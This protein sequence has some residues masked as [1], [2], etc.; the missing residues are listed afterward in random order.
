MYTYD[1]CCGSC[2]YLNTNDYSSSKDRCRCTY[3]EMYCNLKDSKCSYYRY[4]PNKD[5]YDLNHRWHIVSVIRAILPEA[6]NLPGF[7]Q[8]WN[9]RVSVLEKDQRYSAALTLYDIIGPFLARELTHDEN[10]EAVCAA[11]LTE[12]IVA[13]ASLVLKQKYQ[14]ALEK[15]AKMVDALSNHYSTQLQAY[16]KM[17]M[18]EALPSMRKTVRR[19]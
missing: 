13:A 16:L 10:R 8:L 11:L 9:F 1:G 12:W 7:D 6:A 14:E 17:K 5:Y 18:I 4:D 2:I 15:Y 3:R 19:T